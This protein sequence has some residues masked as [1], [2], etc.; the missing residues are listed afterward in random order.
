[1][2]RLCH[3]G[4]SGIFQKDSRHALLAG[5]TLILYIQI[6]GALRSLPQG[7]FLLEER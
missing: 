6:L 4:L 3:S 1:M 5:M 2:H 7:Y